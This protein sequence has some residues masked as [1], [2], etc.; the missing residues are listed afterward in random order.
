MTQR[1]SG[2][3]SRRIVLGGMSAAAATAGTGIFMPAISRAGDR[4]TFTHGLQSGDMAVDSGVVW[5][6]C[7]R[8][9]RV[10]I[11]AATTESF[12]E[13]VH[14]VWVDALPDSDLTAKVALDGL[15]PDQEI[16]Y[17][18]VAQNHAEPTVRSAPLV[19]RFRTAPRNKRNISFVW[20]GDT[21]GQGWGLMKHAAACGPMPLC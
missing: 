15:P 12:K 3:V 9:S 4:P 11:E 18:M 13:V 21:C 5:V 10:H 1:P 17:R 6:R 19:G 7:D 14:R 8:P 20:S 16:F 2:I